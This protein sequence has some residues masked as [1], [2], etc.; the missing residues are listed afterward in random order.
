VRLTYDD[1]V[2]FPHDGKRHELIDGEHLVTA[3]PNTR[4]QRV[5]TRLTGLLWSFVQ[6][7]RLGEV[8][9]APFDVVFSETD[10]V[11]PDLLFVSHARAADTLTDLNMRGAPDLVVEVGSPSTR[12]VDE[13]TKRRLYERYGVAEYWVVDPELDEIKVYR[14]AGDRFER[15]AL[16]AAEQGDVLTSPM[17][18]DLELSLTDVFAA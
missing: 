18:P 4:H 10:V 17:F 6:S 8:F 11:E 1:F 3:A 5:V 7:R 13:T 2:Q 12:K 16:L 14:L 9:V 15:V